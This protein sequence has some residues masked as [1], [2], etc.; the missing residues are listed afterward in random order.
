MM[1]MRF[2]SS[3]RIARSSR[4]RLLFLALVSLCVAWPGMALSAK[5]SRQESQ[6]ATVVSSKHEHECREALASRTASSGR[7]TSG[8]SDAT[9]LGGPIVFADRSMGIRWVTGESADPYFTVLGAT[10]V[11]VK[12]GIRSENR[13]LPEL[14]T[15]YRVRYCSAV[16]P[17]STEE[18]DLLSAVVNELQAFVENEYP[19]AAELPWRFLKIESSVEGGLPHTLGESIVLPEG[20]LDHLAS[21]A[22]SAER[23]KT[24][25]TVG[26]WLLHERLHV[27]QRM[28]RDRFRSLYE[29][30]WKFRFVE[31]LE[32]GAWLD[33]RRLTNPDSGPGYW[34]HRVSEA[35]GG[36]WVWP[37][38]ILDRGLGADA[39]APPPTLEE[40]MLR[41]A[42]DV[43]LGDGRAQVRAGP[44][45][46]AAHAPLNS[47]PGYAARFPFAVELPC[48]D[49][50][51]AD[52]FARIAIED[53]VNGKEAFRSASRNQRWKIV[54][55][56][57]R[58][59][60]LLGARVAPPPG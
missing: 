13:L 34:L 11:W 50:I 24:L 15:E 29:D 23:K 21:Q 43:S 48:P 46:E 3:S 27:V 2:A 39:S 8:D 25:S 28:H 58:F 53:L 35:E 41:I 12:S 47:I 20:F 59:K 60:K 14:R 51:A 33:R 4:L 22:G 44:G 7:P 10:E 30:A 40:S 19:L 57:M 32:R 38:V 36:R 1:E 26:Y 5:R 45:G 17:F 6:D 55:L 37:T 49:E 31:A 52:A 18:K 42:A 56:R 54:D 16:R 9:P